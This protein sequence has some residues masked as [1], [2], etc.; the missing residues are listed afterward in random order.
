ARPVAPVEKP[1]AANGDSGSRPCNAVSSINLLAEGLE[2][3]IVDRFRV[4]DK[5]IENE[6]MVESSVK[7]GDEIA[8]VAYG[9]PARIALNAIEELGRQGVK[10]GLIRPISLWPFP[11]GVFKNLPGSVKN[12]L[13]IELSMGQMLEDVRLGLEGRKP[14]HFYGRAGGSIFEPAEIVAKALEVARGTK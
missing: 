7:E 6:V 5:I 10:A 4:Y 8:I 14:V 9:S 2:K 1:W 13:V 12:V 11:Y 3:M